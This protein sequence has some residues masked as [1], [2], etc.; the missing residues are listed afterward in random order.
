[1]LMASHQ[2]SEWLSPKSWLAV[3]S[4]N[5]G[6]EAKW[7]SPSGRGVQEY[8]ENKP[9]HTHTF[10]ASTC[11]M[12]THIPLAS[13]IANPDSKDGETDSTLDGRKE[14]VTIVAVY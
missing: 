9:H 5:G 14:F 3:G 13:H 12:F 6:N 4:S 1:M 2:L 8:Q 10:E 11:L 7:V